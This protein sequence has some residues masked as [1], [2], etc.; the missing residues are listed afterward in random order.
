M[1]DT[2]RKTRNDADYGDTIAGL[3]RTAEHQLT[4]AFRTFAYMDTY[5]IPQ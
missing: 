2:M 3:E 1:L 5:Q 4:L